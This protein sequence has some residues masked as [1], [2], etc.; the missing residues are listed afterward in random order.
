MCAQPVPS[1]PRFATIHVS[2]W[3]NKTLNNTCVRLAC[4]GKTAHLFCPSRTGDLEGVP[5]AKT[6]YVQPMKDPSFN[7]LNMGGPIFPFSDHPLWRTFWFATM[8]WEG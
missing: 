6:Q 3:K 7:L 5:L 2:T 8:A 1:I 4:P